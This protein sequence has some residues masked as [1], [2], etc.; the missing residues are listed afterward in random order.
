[1]WR[2]MPLDP[3]NWRAIRI[4]RGR[5][6]ECGTDEKELLVGREREHG[7]H[8]IGLIMRVHRVSLRTRS[9]LAIVIDRHQPDMVR[10][11]RVQHK[12]RAARG[13]VY[14]RLGGAAPSLHGVPRRLD[15]QQ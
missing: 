12:K 13:D 15:I 14:Q 9:E 6:V 2:A 10:A 4:R 11:E 5:L 7:G 3:E 8:A 1:M